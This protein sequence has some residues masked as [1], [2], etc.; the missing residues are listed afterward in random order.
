MLYYTGFGIDHES[1][2][3]KGFTCTVDPSARDAVRLYRNCAL[4]APLWLPQH[5]RTKAH[6]WDVFGI[7]R[8]SVIDNAMDLTANSVVLM[9]LVLGVI[10]LRM[11]PRR[12]DLKGLVERTQSSKQ[13]GYI[14]T[15]PGYVSQK[16]MGSKKFGGFDP[17]YKKVRDRAKAKAN[18][19]VADYEAK[20]LETTLD[21]NHAKHP[22]LR[23][24][25]IEVWRDG[26]ELAPLV[27]P[28]G[29]LQIRSVYALTYET[30]LTREGV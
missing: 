4:P 3:I 23:K 10:L 5:L 8:I 27:L 19:T 18:L 26:Q 24:P 25:R 12:G 11:P 22:Q 2:V 16:H 21:Y 28:T 14:S 6:H 17:R 1:T 7:D 30:S 20:L 13:S 9:Y 15:L 29:N